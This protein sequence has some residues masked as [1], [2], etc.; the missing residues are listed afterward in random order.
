MRS[1]VECVL[2]HKL[3]PCPSCPLIKSQIIGLKLGTTEVN[4]G[5]KYYGSRNA[6]GNMVNSDL[7]L[8]MLSPHV[9]A[10]RPCS[11]SSLSPHLPTPPRFLD[12]IP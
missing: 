1:H 3:P 6:C 8:T 7:I 2:L 10:S 5:H 12:S 9:P 11:G 4:V